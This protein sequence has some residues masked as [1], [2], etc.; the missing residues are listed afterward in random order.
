MSYQVHRLGAD[1]VS[2]STLRRTRRIVGSNLDSRVDRHIEQVSC[3]MN[4]NT[5]AFREHIIHSI[6][7]KPLTRPQDTT[8][9]VFLR[10]MSSLSM[11]IDKRY[12]E[13]NAG[14]LYDVD[15]FPLS[16]TLPW[17][18]QI[19]IV[20]MQMMLGG[21][22]IHSGITPTGVGEVR[23]ALADSWMGDPEHVTML[24]TLSTL[25]VT[26]MVNATRQIAGQSPRSRP[27][28]SD[29]DNP[30]LALVELTPEESLDYMVGTMFITD[31]AFNHF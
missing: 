4:G 20:V 13:V 14:R 17:M 12:S 28:P 3:R 27:S 6:S 16:D 8:T 21:A 30:M 29:P 23:D 18:Y 31:M 19:N 9:D 10:S 2:R 26:P 22:M 11:S 24:D 25:L 7:G 1:Q 15:L 5:R